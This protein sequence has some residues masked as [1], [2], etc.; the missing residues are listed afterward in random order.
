MITLDELKRLQRVTVMTYFKVLFQ[1]LPQGTVENHTN[2][3]PKLNQEY[4]RSSPKT[5]P[6]LPTE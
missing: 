6:D 4:I 2:R 3:P 5:C 1:H